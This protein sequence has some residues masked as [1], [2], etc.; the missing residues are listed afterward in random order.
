MVSKDKTFCTKNINYRQSSGVPGKLTAY[1]MCISLLTFNHYM[2][3]SIFIQL[4]L[5]I[6][7]TLPG[8]DLPRD[9]PDYQRHF[10]MMGGGHVENR[11]SLSKAAEHCSTPMCFQRMQKN[12]SSW[13]K[14]T[15]E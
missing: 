1:P 11:H 9:S 10:Y 6:M 2:K 15:S 14:G 8:Q 3:S 12:I 7:S 5:Q 4:T 13:R